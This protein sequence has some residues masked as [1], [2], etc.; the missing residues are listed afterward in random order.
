MEENYFKNKMFSISVVSPVF[1]EEDTLINLVDYFHQKLINSLEEII[2]VY[3][4]RSSEKCIN[5]LKDLEKNFTKVKIIKEEVMKKS[6]NGSAYRQGFKLA[7]GTHILMI[8]S[9]G[10]MDIRTVPKMIKKMEETDCDIVIG[11]R[12]I[13]GGG[14][15]GY[16]FHKFL[17]NVAFHYIF[18]LLFF[19]K[20]KDL[21]C[22]FKL[23]KRHVIDKYKWTAHN[24]EIGAETTLKPLKGRD[25]IEEVPTVWKMTK[26]KKHPLS[27]I[28]N[29][30][31]PILA[32]KILF[33]F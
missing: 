26:G 11:S 27:L 31:Y 15:V 19:T 4:P 23:I 7:K 33:N 13:K 22:G 8:D 24:Q 12:Y 16:A 21:T 5:I 25:V 29:L 17:L 14:F 32:L 9:D 2:F 18:R 20:I 6:G 28:G 3:H 1:S 30:I 10:E